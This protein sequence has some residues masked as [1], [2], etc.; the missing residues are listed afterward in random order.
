MVPVPSETRQLSLLA[1]LKA[2]VLES[3]PGVEPSFS[4]TTPPLLDKRLV[5][6]TVAFSWM[7][8]VSEGIRSPI[9]WKPLLSI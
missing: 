8:D 4:Q 7:K 2:I 9:F 5:W 1:A 3:G 6:M